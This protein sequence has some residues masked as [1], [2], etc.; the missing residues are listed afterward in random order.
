M[1]VLVG[2]ATDIGQVR[3]GNEDSYLVL[4]PLFAVADGMGGHRGGEVASDLAVQTI[5]RLFEQHEGSLIE[6]V[7]RANR[8]VFERSQSDR[9]V[10][11]MGTTLTAVVV[12]DRGGARLAHVGDSRAYLLR[13]GEL[14]LLT[15]D[16][17]LVQRMVDEGELTAE[18]AED[19]PHRHILTRVLGGEGSVSVDEGVLELRQ[20]DRLLLCTD[21]LTGMVRDDEIRSLLQQTSDPQEAAERL[22]HAANG[23]GGVDN[24][25]A[26]VLDVV[27]GSAASSEPPSSSAVSTRTPVS[28]LRTTV[29]PPPPPEE[30]G[31]APLAVRRAAVWTAVALAVIVLG[32]VALRL[33]VDAQWYVGVSDGRVAVFR[34]IPAEVA[35]FDLSSVVVETTIPA[36]EAQALAVYRELPEGITA[37][38]REGANEIVEQIRADVARARTTGT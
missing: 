32:V 21:G 31:G 15:R 19:H 11:G 6:Q 27:D 38:D 5:R 14:D 33:Y 10:S 28:P 18:E 13:D 20:G 25:T 30:R 2:A 36:E 4:D 16:H 17:T 3:E 37:D 22:V 24:I 34:G 7:E 9:A 35:G 23:A 8:A 29:P 1:K 26:V 12:D